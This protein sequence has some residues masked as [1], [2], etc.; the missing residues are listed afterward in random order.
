[1]KDKELFD[2]T[3]GILVKAYFEGVLEHR[4]P[5]ACA[6][7]NMIACAK[8]Y[9]IVG[10]DIRANIRWRDQHFNNIYP[11]WDRVHSLGI[12]DDKMYSPGRIELE[13]TGYSIYDTCRIEGAFERYTYTDDPNGFLGLMAVV[14]V[15]QEIHGCTDEERDQAKALFNEIKE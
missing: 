5:C 11:S 6:V 10:A 14:D 8:G 7:G 1:M 4:T 9:K 12:M 3:V 2:R 15:L 13:S